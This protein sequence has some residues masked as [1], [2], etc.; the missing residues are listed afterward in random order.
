VPL[1]SRGHEGWATI[2]REGAAHRTAIATDAVGFCRGVSLQLP[3]DGAYAADV[4]LQL[5]FGVTIRLIDRSGSLM[6]RVNMAQLMRYIGPG[7]GHS[8]AAGVLTLGDHAHDGHLKGLLH[9]PDQRCQI[10]L[11]G[12]Q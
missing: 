12:G 1:Q 2:V 6:Q 8:A 7:R 3:L 10:V 4:L 11:G 5:L 9:R